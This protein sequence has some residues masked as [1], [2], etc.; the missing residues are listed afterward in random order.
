M[1]CGV[2]GQLHKT[3]HFHPRHRHPLPGM[4]LPRRAWVRLNR[5]H[6]VS[7][8]SAPVCTNGV[9]LL[10]RPVSVAQKN[11][12]STML[13]SNVQSIDLPTDCMA[14][15]LWTM[16]QLNGCSTPAPRS[17]AAMQWF[18]Q[19]AQK[20]EPPSVIR[21]PYNDSATRESHPSAPP[22]CYAPDHT[23]RCCQ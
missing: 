15:R 5:L 14:W 3:P 7:D 16:R 10:L 6:T 9:W 4:I 23:K 21:H 19:L 17:S 8:V 11:K 13:T 2:D 20:K 12:P 1:E 18:Q 22:R